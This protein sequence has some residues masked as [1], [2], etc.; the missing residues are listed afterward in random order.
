MQITYTGIAEVNVYVKAIN[1]YH[2]FSKYKF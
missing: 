1:A 2:K